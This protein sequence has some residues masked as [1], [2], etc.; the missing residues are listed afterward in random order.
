SLD[1]CRD[2]LVDLWLEVF[3]R[4]QRIEN[5]IQRVKFLILLIQKALNARDH[6]RGRLRLLGK[7]AEPF[8][9][10]A[11]LLSRQEIPRN[12]S[13]SILQGIEVDLLPPPPQVFI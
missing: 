1:L 2:R 9:K 4:E 5:L 3:V 12:L 8:E 6:C 11:P 10:L 13:D 7:A